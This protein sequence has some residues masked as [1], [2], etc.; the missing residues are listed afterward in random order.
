MPNLIVIMF[1]LK[2]IV[3]SVGFL[4]K[5][6]VWERLWRAKKFLRVASEKPSCKVKHELSTWLEYKKSWKM[7]TTGF[8]KCLVSKALLRDTCETFC[9]ANLSYLIHQVS[10]HTI[11]THITHIGWKVL[12]REKTLATI[13]VSERLLYIQFPTQSIVFFFNSYLSIS[14]SMRG[15]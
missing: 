15:W 5:S 10:T 8:H 9:F 3:F 6:Y 4:C 12:F 2:Y 14:K 1:N 11:Y 7:V 13:L